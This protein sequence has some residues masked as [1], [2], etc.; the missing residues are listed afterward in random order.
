MCTSIIHREVL[1]GLT[2]LNVNTGGLKIKGTGTMAGAGLELFYSSNVGYIFPYDRGTSAYKALEIRGTSVKIMDQANTTTTNFANG[3]V[4]GVPWTFY[5]ST[6]T[7]AGFSGFTTKSIYYKTLGDTV[8][9]AF[10]IQGTS[11]QI[12][13]QPII[14]CSNNGAAAVAGLLS[15]A[16]SS[17]ICYCYPTPAAGTWTASGTKY[18]LGQFWYHRA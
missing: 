10:Y 11:N 6:S 12:T 5:G 1:M 17:T 14:R 8:Y 9:V 3:D 4:Y 13:Q 15:L 18:A 2:R 7:V 16:T